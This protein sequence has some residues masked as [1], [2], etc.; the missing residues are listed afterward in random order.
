MPLGRRGALFA[1]DERIGIGEAACI[2]APPV[3]RVMKEQ[4]VARHVLGRGDR[5]LP[6]GSQ[7]HELV[8][9]DQALA[10][11]R[12]GIA[13]LPLGIGGDDAALGDGAGAAFGPGLEGGGADCL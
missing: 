10:H 2:A 7:R 9:G 3:A 4:R 12:S 13:G 11:Q 6:V 5:I 1:Q 8:G